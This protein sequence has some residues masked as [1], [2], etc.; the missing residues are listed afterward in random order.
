VQDSGDEGTLSPEVRL[1][2]APCRVVL[3]LVTVPVFSLGFAAALVAVGVVAAQVG[4]RVLGWLDSIWALRLQ[5]ATTLLIIGM[6]VW[7]TAQA[8]R[9]FPSALTL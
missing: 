4:R 6:G 1:R 2:P 8:I 9:Q 5:L 7:L 3:G